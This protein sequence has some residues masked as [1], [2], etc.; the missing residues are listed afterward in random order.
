MDI[1]RIGEKIIK[2]DKIDKT[3][4]KI[5]ELRSKGL[6]QQEVADKLKLDRTFISRLE[7]I[8]SIRRGGLIGLISF[9]VANKK[10]L[11]ELADSYGIEQRIVLSNQERW[12]FVK[13]KSGLG[14]FNE[15]MVV[16]EK[17]RECDTVLILC[18]SK[19]NRLAE[20]LLDNQVIAME[21]APTPVTSDIY[22]DLEEVKKILAQF[23]VE[24]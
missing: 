24:E 14:F 9:P 2:V 12:E 18:S 3:V 23:K 1:Y 16:I 10:E 21:I 7:S 22:V 15:V 5:L 19:W 13:K 20:A 8:G 11:I 17:F 6:A 4:R